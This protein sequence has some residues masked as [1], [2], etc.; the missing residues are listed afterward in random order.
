VDV[1]VQNQVPDREGQVN[2]L[3]EP[4]ITRVV[5]IDLETTG[6][7]P[8][9]DFILEVGFRITDWDGS[10]EIAQFTSLVYTPGWRERLNL[11]DNRPAMEIH[12]ENGLI[13]E[14]EAAEQRADA[15]IGIDN[16]PDVREVESLLCDWL[17]EYEIVRGEP[18]AGS[19]NHLDR[20]FLL[21]HMPQLANF[22]TYRLL[23]VSALREFARLT[24]PD[25][26]KRLEEAFA[27]RTSKHRPQEDIDDSIALYQWLI[28]NYLMV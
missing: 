5:W 18:L 11:G 21:R 4:D 13:A 10:E 17:D 22:F 19:C 8:V 3:I 20:Y 9:D 27:K 14:L 23:D 15:G 24:S 28:D 7:D 1:R 6:L 16:I 26:F 25:L 12:T 2:V